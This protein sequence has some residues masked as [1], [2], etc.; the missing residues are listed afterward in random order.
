M[1]DW[2]IDWDGPVPL[3]DPFQ[4][5]EIPM[6]QPALAEMLEAQ[7]QVSIDPLRNSEVFGVDIFQEALMVAQ[8]VLN[9]Q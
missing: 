2:G 9:R 7:L 4:Q 5:T 3:E 1:S 8:H 6:T